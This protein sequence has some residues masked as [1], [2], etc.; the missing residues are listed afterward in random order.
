MTRGR[1]V[2]IALCID[3]D[4]TL[5]LA[6]CLASLDAVS[7]DRSV[8][9]HVVHPGL[10]HELRNRVTRGLLNLRVHW[11]RIHDAAVSGAHHSVFLSSASLYRLLLG[12]LLPQTLRRVIY[13]DADTIVTGSL[14]PLYDHRLDDDAVVGAVPD[15]QSP[16]AAGPLGPPWQELGLDPSSGYFNSGVLLIDLERWRNDHT[17]HRCLEL[18]RRHSPTWGDQDG[19]NTVLENRWHQL[20]RR[21]NVQ[22]ADVRGSS[23]AWALWTRE[24]RDAVA[25]PGILHYTEGD[26]PW[27]ATSRHPESARWFSSLNRTAWAGWRP[28]EARRPFWHVAARSA[29]GFL[30]ARM[31]HATPQFPA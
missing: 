1:T 6:A 15:A 29:A 31:D 17:G 19:L 27:L 23:I 10:D 12:E 28:A 16:W 25:A 22:S 7:I 21:W 3:A 2:H 26:K 4:F 5:P 30:R 24:I 18:L 11:I 14:A 13:L 9:V 8:E 20:P